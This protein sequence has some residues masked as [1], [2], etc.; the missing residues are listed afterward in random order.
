MG[1]RRS[2]R[3]G[4]CALSFVLLALAG[5]ARAQSLYEQART[6]R[7]RGQLDSAYDLI[8]RAAAA[9]P[10][11]AE[12]QF[13]LGDI[14]CDKA[15]RASMFS[16]M[17]LARKCK[18]AFGRAVELAPDS[19]TYLEALASYLMQ[20]PGIAG[21]DKDSAQKLAD[22]VRARD[23]VRGVFLLTRIWWQGNAGSKA[24]A[25]SAVE[26]LGRSH[27]SDRVVQSRVA[28]WWEGTGRLERALAIWQALVA[29]DPSDPVAQFFVGRE[30]VVM[31]REAREAQRHLR[32]AAAAAPGAVPAPGPGVLTFTPGAP[33]YRLGQTYVQLG[34]PDSARACLERALQIN[35]QLQ[36]A[37]LALDSLGQ[38]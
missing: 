4:S 20:A 10:E 34:M 30:L 37:R 36:P 26:A 25:D 35:P 8:Q 19:L 9:E 22:K 11:R 24:R 21:G 38:H 28:G 15:G 14:A 27:A 12:V 5:Q 7:A 6:A 1:V 31:K 29:R 32:L 13:L 2:A 18:A 16:A 33:W 23:E 3:A 17:G